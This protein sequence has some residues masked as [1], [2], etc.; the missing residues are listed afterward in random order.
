MLAC[1]PP[2]VYPSRARDALKLVK[3]LSQGLKLSCLNDLQHDSSGCYPKVRPA[4]PV[5]EL[6]RGAGSVPVNASSRS[7][8]LLRMTSRTTA[9]GLRFAVKKRRPMYSS[10]IPRISSCTPESS[11][12][13][14]DG[15]STIDVFAV[16]STRCSQSHDIT[17]LG[18]PGSKRMR[19]HEHT[20]RHRHCCDTSPLFMGTAKFRD[21]HYRVW[22]R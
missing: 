5:A 15:T 1:L 13:T 12:I 8:D 17:R 11:K 3:R 21:H 20:G 22:R 16:I 7:A 6:F 2:S 4:P 14:P 18:G 9:C 19:T 10:K